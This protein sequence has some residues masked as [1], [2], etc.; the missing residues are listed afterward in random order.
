MWLTGAAGEEP[1][2]TLALCMG[3]I[4]LIQPTNPVQSLFTEITAQKA[5]KAQEVKQDA[6][7]G[8][9]WRSPMAE[10]FLRQSGK[11]GIG[12]WCSEG[13]QGMV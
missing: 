10:V 7:H 5:Y 1:T 9:R 3:G 2:A 4:G 12:R 13:P 11:R 6:A 8:P